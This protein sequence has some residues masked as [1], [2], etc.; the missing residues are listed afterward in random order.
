MSNMAVI[1]VGL[2]VPDPY[3]LLHIDFHV[4]VEGVVSGWSGDVYVAFDAPADEIN[5]AI[6]TAA[7]AVASGHSVTVTS[8]DAQRVFG[9]A[10]ET[11]S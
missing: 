2:S 3:D 11:V 4:H 1:V 9:G 7:I 6:R 8:A 10:L 5:A